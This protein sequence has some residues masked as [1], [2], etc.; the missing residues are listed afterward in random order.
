MKNVIITIFLILAASATWASGAELLVP[1]QYL[2]IQSAINAAVDGDT[3]IVA[4]GTY[5]G[6][7]NRDIDFLGKAITVRSADP[8]DPNIVAGIIIDCN[9]TQAE[10]HRG[11]YFHNGE[12][13]NSVVDGFTITK[14]YAEQGGGIFC[15][16]SSPTINNCT[17]TGNSA[18]S[19]G[20]MSCVYSSPIIVDCNISYNSAQWG[21]GGLSIYSNAIATV[22]NCVIT[23]NTAY[24]N[25]GLSCSGNGSHLIT[26]SII[27]D[28][29]ATICHGGIY[30]DNTSAEITNCIIC[31][32]EVAGG[33]D[34]GAGI[35][36]NESIV[37]ISNSTFWGNSAGRGG[38]ITCYNASDVAVTNCVLWGNQAP[39]GPQIYLFRTIYPGHPQITISYSDVQGGQQATAIDVG[40][41]LNWGNGNIDTDPCFVDAANDDYHLL[42]A[43]PCINTGDPNYVPEPNETDLDGLPRV[44]GA[45][46]DMGAFEFNHQPVADAG[47][48]QTV[49]AWIDGFADVNLDGS[50][51]YDDDNDVLDY[52]WSWT[53]GPDSYEANGINPTIKLPVGKHTI[54][55][56]V[57]DGLDLSEPDYCTIIVIKAVRGKLMITP[58]VIETKTCGRWIL[59]TL[60]LP[61]VISERVNTK[62]PLRLYP[63]GIE[64][65]YQHFSKYGKFGPTF[66]LAYFDKQQVIDALG[67]G[68]F[69]VSVVGEFLSGR[70][71]FGSDTIKIISPKPKQPHHWH[72]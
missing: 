27:S 43:S 58:R 50:G 36:C 56:V 33:N 25:A 60:Y 26:N 48:N 5:T 64:A 47:P 52:Y 22:K 3:V 21:H 67:P 13:A 65:K 59:A 44:I 11:F 14:G 35:V 62:E 8:N 42:P 30:F 71:L 2:T 40:C 53:L 6:P 15:Y 16:Q 54:E 31:G 55:L 57:D 9:G 28:N 39:V 1:T 29:Y 19:S 45:R 24:V 51:S 32:N 69:D 49:Y 41:T 34:Y 63:G 18:S 70:F 20:G 61:S 37:T 12:D 10:P 38:G 23:G 17:L 4:P 7:G 46:V 68:Q 72:W 66:A